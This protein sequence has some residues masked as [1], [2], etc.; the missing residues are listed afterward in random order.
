[1][2]DCDD[3]GGWGCRECDPGWPGEEFAEE[4]SD[5]VWSGS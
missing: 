1:M 3:C 4:A 5:A 2:T